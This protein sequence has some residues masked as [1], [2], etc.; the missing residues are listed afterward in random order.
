MIL[1]V[2]C[3]QH[4]SFNN[5]R[6]EHIEGYNAWYLDPYISD[7][8]TIGTLPRKRWFTPD[9]AKQFQLN[10]PGNYE[11]EVNLNGKITSCK[12]AK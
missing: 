3:V 7:S 9:Q 4:I 1:E 2:I 8:N 6:N 12:K 5:D 11:V 10:A